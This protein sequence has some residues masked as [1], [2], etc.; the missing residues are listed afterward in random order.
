MNKTKL[1]KI[2]VLVLGIII[3]PATL[4]NVFGFLSNYSGNFGLDLVL[5]GA[6]GYF[7]TIIVYRSIANTTLRDTTLLSSLMVM[8]LGIHTYNDQLPSYIVFPF[9]LMVLSSLWLIVMGKRFGLSEPLYPI[10]TLL[11]LVC[12]IS[13]YVITCLAYSGT[14]GAIYG[15][16]PIGHC[17]PVL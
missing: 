17:L 16:L 5:L 8:A 12:I 3:I 15:G 13:T 7:Y 9:V 6:F 2:M 11:G 10:R 14:F 1:Q 4:Y